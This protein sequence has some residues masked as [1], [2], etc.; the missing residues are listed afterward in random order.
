MSLDFTTDV[1]LDER[2]GVV[3]PK[4]LVLLHWPLQRKLVVGFP[5][6]RLWV[7]QV[8]RFAKMAP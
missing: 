2:I 8:E 7:A 1:K 3:S 5:N 6:H 4:M